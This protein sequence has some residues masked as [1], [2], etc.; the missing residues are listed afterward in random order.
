MAYTESAHN[1]ASRVKCPFSTDCAPTKK[2]ENRKSRTAPQTR[3]IPTRTKIKFEDSSSTTTKIEH[4]TESCRPL[5]QKGTFFL[6]KLKISKRS[7][8]FENV[9]RKSTRLNSSHVRIS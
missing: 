3:F 1:L 7:L 9:D 5:A 6:L 4:I 8:I 2:K